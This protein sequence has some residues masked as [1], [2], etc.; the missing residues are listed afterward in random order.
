MLYDNLF[1]HFSNLDNVFPAPSSRELTSDSV[2][3][4][5]VNY[6]KGLNF[7]VFVKQQKSE[8]FQQINT[9]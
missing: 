9:K 2:T 7:L 5:L 8:V 3:P 4:T 1:C 6:E